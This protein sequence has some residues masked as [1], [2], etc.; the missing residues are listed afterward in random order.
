MPVTEIDDPGLFRTASTPRRDLRRP[1]SGSPREGVEGKS[2]TAMCLTDGYGNIIYANPSFYLMTACSGE[3]EE[4]IYL[5]DFLSEIHRPGGTGELRYLTLLIPLVGSRR[6]VKV[7]CQIFT[8]GTSHVTGSRKEER[9]MYMIRQIEHHAAENVEDIEF[10]NLDPSKRDI[11]PPASGPGTRAA[12]QIESVAGMPRAG[13]GLPDVPVPQ[14]REG[15]PEPVLRDAEKFYEEWKKV[16]QELEDLRK[17]KKDF[18]LLTSHELKTPLTVLSGTFELFRRGKFGEM[19]EIQMKKFGNMERN[20]NRIDELV[21]SMYFLSRAEE[22][23]EEKWELCDIS[24]IIDEVVDDAVMVASGKEQTI[25]CEVP[26]DTRIMGYGKDLTTLFSKLLDNAV[27]YTPEEGKISVN[28]RDVG[29]GVLVKV[30]DTGMG[31]PKEQR[32]RIFDEFYEISDIMQHKDGFGLGL[33]IARKIVQRH[34]G[35]IW[36]ESQVG[37]GSEFHV[38]LPKNAGMENSSEWKHQARTRSICLE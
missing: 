32:E 17:M 15:N 18:M 4:S 6:T 25:H 11:G 16:S 14:I 33:S 20:L 36:V 37:T 24:R 7:N 35:K 38:F 31:I 26:S 23:N 30:K 10:T 29:N 34:G 5:G 8:L 28:L 13:R 19:T 1:G 27:Q 21:T 3:E 22:M 12:L 9:Y 2:E